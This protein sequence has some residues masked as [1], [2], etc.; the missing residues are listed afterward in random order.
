MGTGVDDKHARPFACKLLN[1]FSDPFRAG[2]GVFRKFDD[3]SCR[4][5]RGVYTG[6]GEESAVFE[7]EKETGDAAYDLVA[8]RDDNL[9]KAGVDTVFF[10]V[11]NSFL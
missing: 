2:I 3:L 5:I 4:R 6:I 7:A 8:L 11:F 1:L 9:G 10:A